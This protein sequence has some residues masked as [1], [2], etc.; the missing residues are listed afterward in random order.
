MMGKKVKVSSC[1][2]PTALENMGQTCYVNVILQLFHFIPE[3]VNK[4]SSLS[5][6]PLLKSLH[7]ILTL[8]RSSIAPV[9][10]RIFIAALGSHISKIINTTFK[11]N[12]QHDVPEVLDYI[13]NEL[14]LF[15]ATPVD[16]FTSHLQVSLT[17]QNCFQGTNSEDVSNILKL[18][19]AFSIFDALRNHLAEESLSNINLR[20]CPVCN[21]NEESKRE[22]FFSRLPSVLILQLLRFDFDKTK[23]QILK[24]NSEIRCNDKITISEKVGTTSVAV[25]YKLMA[26]VEH[27]GNYEGGHYVFQG[28]DDKSGSI[29]RCNDTSIVRKGVFTSAN[30]YLLV[31][32][33]L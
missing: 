25:R 11:P 21:S 30:A 22:V 2:I 6:S 27:L 7:L 1:R 10:P 3:L 8:L 29:F 17:C 19:V 26:I 15:S 31:Y 23:K 20:F 33:R 13:L 5:G 14:S 4:I 12:Q 18:P 32:K 16:L 9:N 28:R 24:D